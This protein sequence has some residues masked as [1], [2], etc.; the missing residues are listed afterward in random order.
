MSMDST[1]SSITQLSAATTQSQVQQAAQIAMLKKSMEA[2]AQSVLPLINS[3]A[4][5]TPLG[6]SN[7]PSDTLGSVVNLSA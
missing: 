4:Q 2:Q 3:V 7:N 1:I 6:G 5:T